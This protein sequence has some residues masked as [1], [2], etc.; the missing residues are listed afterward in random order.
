[1]LGII[2]RDDLK[3]VGGAHKLSENTILFYKQD[4]SICGFGDLKGSWNHPVR[5]S[6][7]LSDTLTKNRIWKSLCDTRVISSIKKLRG[8]GGDSY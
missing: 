6:F 3:Y 8:W 2:N 5:E 1:M 4:L 7:F